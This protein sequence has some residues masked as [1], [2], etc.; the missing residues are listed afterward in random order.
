MAGLKAAGILSSQCFGFIMRKRIR[1]LFYSGRLSAR[2]CYSGK[3]ADYMG[4]NA[5]YMV[6]NANSS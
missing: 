6:G 1:Y 2:Y 4:A 3:K 5:Q